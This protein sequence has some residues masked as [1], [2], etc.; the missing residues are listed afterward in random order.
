MLGHVSHT[1]SREIQEFVDKK[2]MVG[3]SE[4]TTLLGRSM[5]RLKNNIKIA[6][7]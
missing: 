3:K 7:K 2:I 5:G 4:G 6:I 1:G